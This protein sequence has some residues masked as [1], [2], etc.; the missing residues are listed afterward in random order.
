MPTKSISGHYPKRG[1]KPPEHMRNEP[2]LNVH[3]THHLRNIVLVTFLALVMILLLLGGLGVKFYR[4]AMQIKSHEELALSYISSLSGEK[5][6]ED[7]DVVNRVIPK[8]QAETSAANHIAHGFV[9]S[10]ASSVPGISRDVKNLQGLVEIVDS[11]SH[12][13][14]P[15]LSNTVRQLVDAKYSQD[16]EQ[17]N[18]KPI[19]EAGTGFAQAD[20]SLQTQSEK[21]KSLPR[22][23]IKEVQQVYTKADKQFSSLA[24][25]VSN[26]N[27][28]IHVLPQLLGVQ[29]PRTYIIAAQTPSESRSSGGLIGSLGSMNANNG[30]VKVNDFHP[31]TE[32]VPLGSGRTSDSDKIFS[33]PLP[34]SFDI[35]DL[36]AYPDFSQTAQAVN[37]RW[38]RS[39]Y[40]GQ[41][42]GVIMLDPVFIQEVIRISGNVQTTS[43]QVL[44]GDNTAKYFMND[45]YKTVP[46]DEQDDVFADVAKQSMNSVF[47]KMNTKKLLALS[48]LLEPMAQQRHLYVYTF[49]EDEAVNFQDAGLA[50]EAPNNEE[51]PETGIYLNQNNPSKLDW[52]LHRKTDI[53]RTSCMA[54][55][56]Q[57]YH[58]KF[59]MTNEITSRDL[60]TLNSYILGGNYNFTA[61][62]TALEKVLFYPPAGGSITNIILK[63]EG[64]Q[65]KS[66]TL[67][68]KQLYSSL[69]SIPPGETVTYEYDVTTSAKAKTDLTLDQT[70]MGWTDLGVTYNYGT[71][72]NEN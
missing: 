31:N 39:P 57:T 37:D 5:I 49:H 62:G 53:V 4:D 43:G 54:G 32:F 35:R 66:A 24:D 61:K 41:V 11:T 59:T 30:Q 28:A 20:K 19:T 13:S 21:L 60:S 51:K 34:F 3:E 48:K 71:C 33:A 69:A 1:K 56:K 2:N 7:P 70:P 36:A 25:T 68:G 10:F 40:A 64:W 47:T 6:T 67:N 46:V 16:N 12:E 50:K 14:L 58:V 45:I 52:Y 18:L 26:L 9:W 15:M 27:Q 23:R 72:T 65:P 22:P 29:S 44:T 17:I 8:M 42:D 38:Q 63:G 55:G